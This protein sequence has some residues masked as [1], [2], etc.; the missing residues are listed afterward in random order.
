MGQ[1]PGSRKSRAEKVSKDILRPARKQYSVKEKIRIVSDGTK[2]WEPS[3]SAHRSNAD[4]GRMS[5]YGMTGHAD[6]AKVTVAL[7][8]RGAAA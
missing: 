6:F 1:N 3:F 7:A 2:G 8:D 4:M 5:A